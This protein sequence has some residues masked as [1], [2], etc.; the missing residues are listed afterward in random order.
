MGGKSGGRAP[1][2]PDPRETAA[3]QAAANR[4]AAIAQAQLNMIDQWTPYGSLRY[5]QIGGTGPQFDQAGYDQAMA[6]WQRAGGSSRG[7]EQPLGYLQWL[8]RQQDGG[9]SADWR[10][11]RDDFNA[12]ERARGPM[13]DRQNFYTNPGGAEG[14]PRYRAITELSPEEQAI[15]DLQQSGRLQFG[16][17]AD[18]QLG[19]ISDTLSNPFTMDR[20][21]PAPTINEETRQSVL[22][23]IMARQQP[24][25]DRTYDQLQ[26]RLA[27]QGLTDPNSEAYRNAVDE[28]YRA[29]NDFGLAAG[30]A[31]LGQASQLY[32]L[33]QDAR[34]RAIQEALMER[35]VPLN[36]LAAMMS[37]SQV[38]MPQFQPVPQSQVA[39]ADVMGATYADYNARMNQWQQDQAR[40]A[41]GMQGLFGLL[42][43]GASIAAPYMMGPAGAAAGAGSSAP[44][45][46]NFVWSDRR[47]KCGIRRIGTLR[48]GIPLYAYRYIWGGPRQI[49]VMADEARRIRPKAVKRLGLFDAVNYREVLA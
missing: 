36:E 17:I 4:E 30:Q 38:Q 43:T 7:G 6:A 16:Q 11:Y 25:F 3:A 24:Q 42:G 28:F 46:T 19:Q 2:P 1:D 14:V 21:G 15:F 39:P 26:T 23:D 34:S 22:D 20:F 44:F 48:N 35:Q 37:G 9:S 8:N 27:G 18:R 5:E 13:P 40:S 12:S 45:A 29:Q 47:L 31:A 10:A 41:A 49:G 33:E 32:G